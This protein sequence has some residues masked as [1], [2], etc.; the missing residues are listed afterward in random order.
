MCIFTDL[1]HEDFSLIIRTN[2][3]SSEQILSE[4]CSNANDWREIFMKQSVENTDKLTSIS[5]W[6][7]NYEMIQE[8]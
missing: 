2:F 1:F 4:I 3:R 8:N 5:L 6:I 7:L